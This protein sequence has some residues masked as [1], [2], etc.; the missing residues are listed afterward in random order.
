MDGLMGGCMDGL[1]LD[2]STPCHA[3]CHAYNEH[4]TCI[5]VVVVRQHEARGE[6]AAHHLLLQTDLLSVGVGTGSV[7]IVMVFAKREDQREEGINLRLTETAEGP[8]P[9]ETIQFKEYTHSRLAIVI[10][11]PLMLGVEAVEDAV[12]LAVFL[13]PGQGALEALPAFVKDAG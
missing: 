5:P 13:V 7:V 1:D 3:C 11:S 4:E 9:K 10:F 6:G 12:L 8:I 2:Q